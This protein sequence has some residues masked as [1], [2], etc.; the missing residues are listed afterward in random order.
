MVAA[1]RIRGRSGPQKY[2]V[3]DEC[4]EV[5]QKSL[6]APIKQAR[7]LGISFWLACQNLSD[8]VTPGVDFL[9]VVLGNTSVRVHFSATD[10]LA[11]DYI[12]RSSGEAVRIVRGRADTVTQFEFGH[13]NVGVSHQ[14]Q[15]QIVPRYTQDDVNRLNATPGLCLFEAT[16]KAGFTRLN[17]PVFVRAPFT[18]SAAEYQRRKDMPLA[19]AEP[20]HGRQPG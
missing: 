14:R 16:P 18:M 13:Q 19:G 15:E 7:D 20:L 10:P 9:N 17:H 11:R 6:A 2:V 8:L 4:Q 1:A 5:M 12:T 3:I